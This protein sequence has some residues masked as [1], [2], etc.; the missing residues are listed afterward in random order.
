MSNQ[1][2]PQSAKKANPLSN[3]FRQPKMYMRLPSHGQFYPEGALDKS[4]IDEYPVYAMTAKDELMFKTPD[5]LMNGQ[6]TVEVIKS[7]IPAIKNPWAMPSLDL[8]AVL[9]A[10][11]IATYGEHMDMHATCPAC[12]HYNDFTLNLVQYLDT[13]AQTNYDTE[14]SVPPLHIRIRPYSYKEISRTALKSLEQQKIF[15][16]V[17]DED[18]SDEEKIERFGE[19]FVKLTQLTV[20]V[21]SGC[22]TQIITPEG[23]VDDL[24]A[25]NEF[26]EN[27]PSDVFN[28][29]NDR[30]MTLKEQMS[31]K[32]QNVSCSECS[33]SWSVEV[34]MDQTNFFGKGS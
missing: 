29:I 20:D 26:V 32:A 27:A 12:Q 9:I 18:M 30:V 24:E 31:L 7:C 8:D 34:S 19:S 2:I 3:Y 17:N 22:I 25:I 1:T 28:A 15:N 21:V 23:V 13:I 5:A 6:A 33:H 11:R 16:V 10:I 14:I 4:E